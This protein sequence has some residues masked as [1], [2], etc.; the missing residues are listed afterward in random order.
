MQEV[1]VSFETGV[2]AG[3]EIEYA[4][5]NALRHGCMVLQSIESALKDEGEPQGPRIFAMLILGQAT[6]RGF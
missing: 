3:D 5:K 6:S 2:E 1:G 4:K